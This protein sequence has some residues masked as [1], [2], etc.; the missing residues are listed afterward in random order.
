MF[1]AALLTVCLV[2][3]GIARHYISMISMISMI[4]Y[5]IS[6][7]I[8]ICLCWCYLYLYI[9]IFVVSVPV[10]VCLVQLFSAPRR[11]TLANAV[12]NE[13]PGK[14]DIMFL[15]PY[16]Q[17]FPSRQISRTPNLRTVNGKQLFF[18]IHWSFSV[19]FLG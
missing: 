11:P 2:R 17:W 10:S 15:R 7:M 13:N 6:I 19:A 5:L 14:V 4:S 1:N 12:P 16:N 8:S 3:F 9:L 18:I